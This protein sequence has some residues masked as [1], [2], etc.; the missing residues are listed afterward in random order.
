MKETVI[1]ATG[2]AHFFW[3]QTPPPLPFEYR[4][5]H[6]QPPPVLVSLRV[7]ASAGAK[8]PDL[9]TCRQ[10]QAPRCMCFFK[11]PWPGR[12]SRCPAIATPLSTETPPQSPPR[13]FPCSHP[14]KG[15]IRRKGASGVAL[16]AVRQ[17]VGGGFQ[18]GWGRLLS[19]TNAIE[20]GTWRQGDNGW[21][22][23]GRAGGVPPPPSNAS[24]LTHYG[25]RGVSTAAFCRHLFV[26]YLS[27]IHYN[28]LT[29]ILED[30]AFEEEPAYVR[31][32]LIRRSRVGPAMV[33]HV[34]VL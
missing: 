10:Q 18:S 25:P 13:T 29:H 3:S 19:A 12:L 15:C 9:G 34:R 24:L 22:Q 14:G 17:A 27:P 31:R 33:D 30:G 28:S 7:E 26:S 4:F 8:Q 1:W 16:E 5:A 6:P 20:A 32:G 21:A 2:G 11:L 23:A